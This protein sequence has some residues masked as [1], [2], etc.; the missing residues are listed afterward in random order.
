[1]KTKYNVIAFIVIGVLGTLSHFVYEWSDFNKVLGYFFAINESTWEHLKL[2]FF[3]TVLFSFI[4]FFFVKHEIENYIP[5]V[6]ISVIVGM[7]SIIVLFYSYTGFLGYSIDA[8]NI[9]IFYMG[10][11]IML[12]VKNKIISNEI[13]SSTNANLFFLVLGGIIAFLFIMFTYSP[14]TLGVFT[15]PAT[16]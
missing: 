12:I 15:P 6:I 9:A 7:I 14:P 16:E 3:P 13:F 10:L 5:S 8:I 2:L 4:E 1:M 11:I